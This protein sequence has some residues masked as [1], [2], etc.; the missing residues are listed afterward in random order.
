MIVVMAYRRPI[1]ERRDM[2]LAAAAD[3][4]KW[5]RLRWSVSRMT[6]ARLRLPAPRLGSERL[7][8]LSTEAHGFFEGLGGI[9]VK[10]DELVP[11]RRPLDFLRH[12]LQ[13]GDLLLKGLDAPLALGLGHPPWLR[14]FLGWGGR[15]LAVG[16]RRRGRL[17]L[18][19]G[20]LLWRKLSV[21]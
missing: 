3:S 9:R 14:H 15:R 10:S 1:E 5:T 20:S 6:I 13:A 16:G 4:G 7:A 17:L 18:G 11:L 21:Y 19:H 8:P 12:G 2:I